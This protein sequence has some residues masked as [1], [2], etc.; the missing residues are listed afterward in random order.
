MFADKLNIVANLDK[1]FHC[2][3]T[4]YLEVTTFFRKKHEKPKLILQ[5]YVIRILDPI[6]GRNRDHE[7]RFRQHFEFLHS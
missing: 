7:L 5:E 3:V 1:K 2:Q 6:L 4:A